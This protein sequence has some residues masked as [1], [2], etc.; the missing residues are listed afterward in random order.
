MLI[1]LV[2][3]VFIPLFDIG[4]LTWMVFF[5]PLFDTYWSTH[6]DGFLSPC[7]IQGGPLMWMVFFYFRLK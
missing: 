5:I 4:P 7:L 1:I 2:W 3:M 6:M